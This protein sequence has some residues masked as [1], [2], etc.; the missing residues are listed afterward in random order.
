MDEIYDWIV[1]G[2][3]ITGSVLAYE[4]AKQGLSVLL[5]E[6]DHKPHNATLYSYGGLAYWSGTDDVTRQLAEEGIKIY[7]QL[8]AELGQSVEFRELDLLLTIDRYADPKTIAAQYDK[9]AIAPQ[10][11]SP[12]EACELE[13][14][15]NPDAIAGALRLPHGHIHPQKTNLAYQAAF[16]TL[17]GRLVYERLEG[18]LWNGDRLTGVKTNRKSYGADRIVVC[19]GGLGRSL[20]KSAG[21]DFPLYFTHSQVIRTLPSDRQLQAL[22]MPATLQRFNLEDDAA[23]PERKLEWQAAIA[24][25]GEQILDIGAIQ[26]LDGSLC[27]GQMSQIIPNPQANLD[28][29]RIESE[30]RQGIAKIL[31]S[32]AQLAGTCHHCLVAFTPRSCPLVGEIIPNS[33]LYSFSGFTSTLLFAPPLARHFSQWVMTG[34][35]EIL[36][37]WAIA[38]S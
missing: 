34:E 23:Q 25:D 11:L 28:L 27:L 19:A 6:K 9:F 12:D 15:L 4:L 21:I 22:I 7:R 16:S 37:Q 31:P 10:L 14:L 33:G 24:E 1:I 20:L 8:T 13:P 17:S 38:P 5:L 35:D 2:A 3:G 29:K 36:S 30:I 26:F 32:L 18:L